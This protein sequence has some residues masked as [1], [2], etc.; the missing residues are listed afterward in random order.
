M[1]VSLIFGAILSR[2]KGDYYALVCFGFNVIVFSAFLNLDKITRGPLGIPGIPRPSL[3][4]FSF[5]SNLIFLILSLIFVMIVFSICKSIRDSSFGRALKGIRE[6]EQALQV[7][8]YKTHIYKLII[9]SISA[10]LAS[11][12]GALFASYISFVDPSTFTLTESVYILSIVILGGLASLEGSLAGAAFL[13]I[14]PEALRFVGF[15]PDIAAQMRV[16]VYG[17]LLILLMLYRPKGFMGEYK[18]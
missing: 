13:V 17:L 9:F 2:F 18:I 1:A 5:S 14:L 12:A 15:S 16:A 7:F 4:G 8:G 6:D 3:F 10:S 11:I